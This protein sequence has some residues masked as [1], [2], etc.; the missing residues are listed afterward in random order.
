MCV[1]KIVYIRNKVLAEMLNLLHFKL[2]QYSIS[3]QIFEEVAMGFSLQIRIHG[4]VNKI[5]LSNF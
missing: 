5:N 4:D 2:I 1:I 3:Y